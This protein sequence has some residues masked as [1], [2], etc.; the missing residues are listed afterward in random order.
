MICSL[1]LKPLGF[2]LA[3]LKMCTSFGEVCQNVAPFM[4]SPGGAATLAGTAGHILVQGLESSCFA[5][6]QQIAGQGLIPA[7]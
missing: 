2:I 4:G 7:Q 6:L 5:G 3:A 1:D